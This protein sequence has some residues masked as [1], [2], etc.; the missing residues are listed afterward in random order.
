M[1]FLG[2]PF[3]LHFVRTDQPHRAVYRYKAT[4]MR[5]QLELQNLARVLGAWRAST[6][7]RAT[8][9]AAQRRWQ[10]QGVHELVR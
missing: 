9:S 5:R 8:K 4:R 3:R 7:S 1:T 2:S 6:F 10:H